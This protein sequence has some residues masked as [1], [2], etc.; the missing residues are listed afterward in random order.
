M[1]NVGSRY[2]SQIVIDQDGTVQGWIDSHD[3]FLQA[4]SFIS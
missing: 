2:G 1:G 4:F 3:G